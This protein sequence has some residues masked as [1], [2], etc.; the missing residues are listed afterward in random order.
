MSVEYFNPSSNQTCSI[1]PAPQ[2]RFGHT[3][4]NLTICGGKDKNDFLQTCIT[5]SSGDWVTTNTLEQAR[6]EHSSWQTDQGI[7]L[8][9]G[10]ESPNTSEMISATSG[11]SEPFFTMEYNTK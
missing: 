3:M 6:I 7:V 2:D 10:F 11:H 9:G 1:P 8:M 5:F 4:D